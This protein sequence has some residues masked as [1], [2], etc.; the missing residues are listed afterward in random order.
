MRPMKINE[1]ALK[2][3]NGK[4][5]EHACSAAAACKCMRL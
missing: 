1:Y 2:P 5:S 4:K 3:F